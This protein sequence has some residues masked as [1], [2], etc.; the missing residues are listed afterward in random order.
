MGSAARVGT[1]STIFAAPKAI[2]E[3]ALGDLD[4]AAETILMNL[5]A[6]SALGGFSSLGVNL[7][8]RIPG[9]VSKGAELASKGADE[10]TRALTVGRSP[11]VRAA[12]E[13]AANPTEL[14][15]V[16]NYEK[17]ID[18]YTRDI[19]QASEPF[20]QGIKSVRETSILHKKSQMSGLVDTGGW[21][22]QKEAFGR[23]WNDFNILV[24]ELDSTQSKGG[25]EIPLNKIK[26]W[27]A[28]KTK[29]LMEILDNKDS[30]GLFIFADNH[31]KEIGKLAKYQ[32]EAYG[33]APGAREFEAIYPSFQRYLEDPMWGA[34][35]AAQKEYNRA[36]SQSLSYQK[37]F[38]EFF[39][40]QYGFTEGRPD[41]VIDPAKIKPFL[42]SMNGAEN[43]LKV[44]AWRDFTTGVKA[45]IDANKKWY[46]YSD[47]TEKTKR[48]S[49]LTIWQ[50]L[51]KK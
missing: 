45:E 41:E 16:E 39:T 19:T 31:K 26:K 7:L 3:A 2:T 1:E 34:A 32:V 22:Q 8:K 4:A 27:R 20:F 12:I 42:G 47:A 5:G 37:P 48:C 14:A 21:E 25:I 49:L 30:V 11:E 23:L 15:K 9:A 40:K 29:E 6:G 50:I 17:T 43:D 46:S 38:R 24:H 51:F 10:A 35:G 28:D 36:I 44:A 13:K 18:H 33:L